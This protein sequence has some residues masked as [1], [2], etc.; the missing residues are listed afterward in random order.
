MSGLV[1]FAL[2]TIGLTNILVHGRILDLIKISGKSV[3]EWMNTPEFL[4]EMLGCY[5]CTG[6]WAGI[7]VGLFFL[8]FVPWWLILLYGFAGSV[9]AQTYTDLM[10]LLRSK[11][12]FELPEEN[13]A[14]EETP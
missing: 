7:I 11:I 5:E 12:E 1:L 8:H 6:F 10:Y 13:D 9:L 3:R 14:T 4:K 2:A